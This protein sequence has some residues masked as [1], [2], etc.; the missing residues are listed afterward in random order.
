[1]ERQRIS[2][3][4][5]SIDFGREARGRQMDEWSPLRTSGPW[6]NC[7]QQAKAR[8]EVE[9]H[10]SVLTNASVSLIDQSLLGN[11]IAGHWPTSQD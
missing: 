3:T 9:L 8:L 11:E 4:T 10:K 2:L 5:R 6:L 1:V 7:C